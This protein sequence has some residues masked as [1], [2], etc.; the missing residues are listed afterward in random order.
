MPGIFKK[1]IRKPDDFFDFCPMA[2]DQ[3]SPDQRNHWPLLWYGLALGL[4]LVALQFARYRFLLLDD[5]R[6]I[7]FGLVA[8]VFTCLGLWAGFRVTAGR[9]K[10]EK[11]EN[12]AP[13]PAPGLEQ[14]LEKLGI[15]PREFEVLQL[16]AQGL[17]NREIAARLYVSLNTVKT[18]TSNLFSKL[19]AQRRTQAVGKAQAL[20]LLPQAHPKV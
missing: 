4:L 3:H 1:V 13:L 16:I 14:V 20:G 18:H 15:T 19:D 8:L 17:S 7:Y 10:N 12:S 11:K 2:L 5:A 6:E 9:R